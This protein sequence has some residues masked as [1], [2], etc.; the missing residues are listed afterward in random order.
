MSLPRF[1]YL[2]AGSVEEAIT[3]LQG[4]PSARLLA[5]GTDLLANLKNGLG[6]PSHLV[7]IEPGSGLEG[8]RWDQKDGLWV[9]ALTSLAELTASRLVYRHAPGLALAANRVAAHQHRAM[10]TLGGN[11]LQDSRCLWYNQSAWWRSGQETCFKAGGR[12]CLAVQK[13]KVCYACYHGDLAPVLIVL[14]AEAH[15]QGPEGFR[16]EKVEKLFSGEGVRPN[17]LGRSEILTRFRI[18]PAG[19]ERT[20]VYLKEADRSAIDFPTLGLAVSALP[21]AKTWR[22]CFT[23]VDRGPVR[24]VRAEEFF[25]AKGGVAGI[26]E[27]DLPKL[28]P[29]PVNNSRTGPAEKRRL[30]R[31]LLIRAADLASREGGL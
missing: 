11:I 1:D 31:R 5:G 12:V 7:R 24:S 29:K 30:M 28:E 25:S 20:T 9:G 13:G 3:I 2:R 16:I 19:L 22:I 18:P 21:Q 27:D 26:N 23:A 10:G 14:G 17:T 6:D 4:N 8:I 15:I